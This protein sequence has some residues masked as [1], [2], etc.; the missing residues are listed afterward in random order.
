MMGS[1]STGSCRKPFADSALMLTMRHF[2]KYSTAMIVIKHKAVPEREVR[3]WEVS[4]R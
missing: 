1:A 2:K 3:T 4:A